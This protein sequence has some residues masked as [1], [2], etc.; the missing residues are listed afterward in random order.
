[1]VEAGLEERR[2]V[3]RFRLRRLTVPNPKSVRRVIRDRRGRR[4][5][6]PRMDDLLRR[7]IPQP[8]LSLGEIRMDIFSTVCDEKIRF[9]L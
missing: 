3:R 5:P 9:L 4:V 8:L 7:R 2:L 6:T 1:M